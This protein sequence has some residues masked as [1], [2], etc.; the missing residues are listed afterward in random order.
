MN[1]QRNEIPGYEGSVGPGPK[2]Y[3]QPHVY[4]QSIYSGSGNCVCGRGLGDW[5]H[6]QAAPGVDIPDGMRPSRPKPVVETNQTGIDWK[7]RE[8]DFQYW[9]SGH[10]D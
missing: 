10:G 4:A 9:M 7:K 8:E 1:E 2:Q 3:S 6:V 5:K